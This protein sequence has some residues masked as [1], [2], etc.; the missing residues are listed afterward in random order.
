MEA[1]RLCIRLQYS[2]T[3]IPA[4]CAAISAGVP[5]SSVAQIK[6]TSSPAL[7]RYLAMRSAGNIEPTKFPRCFIP[8][9]YGNALV[10]KY[11]TCD[12]YMKCISSRRI[13]DT[14]CL[15][16]LSADIILQFRQYRVI[17]L[18]ER[19]AR[20]ASPAV[21]TEHHP[22]SSYIC[23][24]GVT[25]PLQRT[26]ALDCRKTTLYCLNCNHDTTNLYSVVCFSHERSCN[27][28]YRLARKR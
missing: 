26:P 18:C 23:G 6:R 25:R 17:F 21:C 7:R 14:D 13:R 12:L 19:I 27:M 2:S 11:L 24:L 9:I 3:S 22:C 28:D 5:C 10:I 20:C 8:L 15:L 16:R 1:C 4:S